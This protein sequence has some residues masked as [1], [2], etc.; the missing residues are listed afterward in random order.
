MVK[1]RL[2][3]LGRH[4]NPYFRIVAIDSKTRRDGEYIELLGTYEPF[5][6][7]VDIKEDLAMK[8]LMVGAQPSDT[9]KSFLQEKGIW[10]KFAAQKLANKTSKAEANPKSK[11][12]AKKPVAKKPASK[13]AVKKA[14]KK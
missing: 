6:G 3:R 7:K 9:V 12:T 14:T 11:E 4:K 1:I 5:S 13:P 2:T 8:W 10:K